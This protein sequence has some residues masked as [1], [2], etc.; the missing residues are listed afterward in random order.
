[1]LGDNSALIEKAQERLTEINQPDIRMAL[2][3]KRA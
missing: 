2:V 1:M 3:K